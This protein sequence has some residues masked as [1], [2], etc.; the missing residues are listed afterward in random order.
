MAKVGSFVV[1]CFL[2]AV[3][4]AGVIL[5]RVF[6]ADTPPSPHFV[7]VERHEKKDGYSF[8]VVLPHAQ[9][10]PPRSTDDRFNAWMERYA[11]DLQRRFEEQIRNRPPDI[12]PNYYVTLNAEVEYDRNDFG[13]FL[14]SGKTFTGYTLAAPYYESVLY[15]FR[16]GRFYKL[17]DLFKPG[18]RYLD[19]L[20]RYCID[21]LENPRS[22]S[23]DDWLRRGA[24]PE[25]RNYSIFYVRPNALVIVFPPYQIASTTA[26]LRKIEVPLPIIKDMLAPHGPFDTSHF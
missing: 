26:T 19:V 18:V 25:E 14:L 1:C 24:G 15:D 7:L 17:R 5:G 11:R 3:L 22:Q 16:H 20:S 23:A 4:A 8:D 6:A 21:Q 10:Q 2:S 13:S 12:G 9:S